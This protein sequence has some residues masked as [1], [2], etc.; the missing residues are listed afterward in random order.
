[1]K[2]Q[3]F[4]LTAAARLIDSASALAAP[5]GTSLVDDVKLFAATELPATEQ[6]PAGLMTK[7]PGENIALGRPCTLEPRPTY[8]YCTDPDDP[9]QL[10]DGEY[11]IGNFWTQKTTVGWQNTPMAQITMDLGKV[12]PICGVSFN[13][14]AG[15]SG[16]G[17]P[18]AINVLVSDDGWSFHEAGELVSL[19]VEHGLPPNDGYGVHRYWTGKL[20]AHGRYV[21]VLPVGGPYIFV[22]EIEVWRGPDA[23]MSQPFKG[24][25]VTDF[26]TFC[27]RGQVRSA[28]IRRIASDVQELRT[29]SSPK[30]D[31]ELTAIIAEAIMLP[32]V[33]SDAFRA[34][35][36]LNELHARLFRVQAAMWRAQGRAALTAWQ[37]PLWDPL[38]PIA[39]MPQSPQSPRVE[40]AMMQGEYRAGAFNLSNASERELT[41][42]LRM[43]DLPGGSNPNL[44]TVHEVAWTDT[45]RGVPVAAAL[46]VAQRNGD[47]F[48]IHVPSGMT[49]QV[50]LTF[51]PTD[52]A[53]GL[54]EGRIVVRGDGVPQLVVPVKL[55]ISA[56][57]F[58]AQ[59]TLQLGGFDYTS[60]DQHYGV[61]LKNR[62][63][64]IAH[65]REHFVDTPWGSAS[66]M[67]MPPK[68]DRFDQWVKRW[69]GARQ[70][71]ILISAGAAWGGQKIGTPAF[72]KGV[73]AWFSAYAKHWRE[74]GLDPKQVG[75]LLVDEPNLPE[76]AETIMAW[77]KAIRA[78]EPGVTIWEDPGYTDPASV[79][80]MLAMCDVLCPHRPFWL[81]AGP[82]FHA[83]Y[84]QQRAAGRK[85][86]FYSCTGPVRTLDPYAYHRMQ[87]WTCWQQGAIGMHYWAFGD[88][89][90]GSDWNEYAAPATSFSPTFLAPDSVTAAK[91]M[92]AIREGVEDYEYFILLRDRIAAI[93]RAGKPHEKLAAAKT[94][95]ATAADRVL[96][97][98]GTD[99]LGWNDAKDRTLADRVRVELLDALEALAR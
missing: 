28:V 53:P 59:P 45:K 91:P 93:E 29:A 34:V 69:P 5:A 90:S 2:K 83:V 76:H 42:R 21:K 63:A 7:S 35:L 49:R 62:D 94:L 74:M 26:K 6:A 22:D 17:W 78:V 4:A 61:T 47:D 72:D 77:I 66:V 25:P 70:Y 80:S 37:S 27:Q 95:L 55:R 84:Q 51:H 57:R 36:P 16:V 52:T 3:T 9:K 81:N 67:P 39:P 68:F 48:L 89:G 82:K 92:E 99:K 58:P 38:N 24:E 32:D 64:L 23:L 87:A 18:T 54:H 14:A 41:L 60:S 12:Q 19:S 46:P 96:N 65:L 20:T 97:A 10:T 13:T 86:E 30:F 75:I 50:W 88:N 8:S 79:K 40:V 73:G 56:L 44:I 71:R 98:P 31:A 1:M 15:S 43:E 11:S 85:L 33:S